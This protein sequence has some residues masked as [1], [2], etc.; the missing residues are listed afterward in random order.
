MTSSCERRVIAAPDALG[1]AMARTPD[2]RD[3]RGEDRV[4][5]GA[6]AVAA[7]AARLTG[8]AQGWSVGWSEGMAAAR[9]NAEREL[10]A[11]QERARAEDARRAAHVEAATAGLRRAASELEAHL[12]RVEARLAD[13]AVELA[14]AVTAAVLGDAAAGQSAAEVVR[15][16]LAQVEAGETAVVRLSPACAAE[17]DTASLP[18]SVSVRPDASLSTGEALVDLVDGVVDLRL[19]AALERVRQV[20]G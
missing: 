14:L 13:Q 12:E 3:G 19:G 4:A 16:A 17:V 20:L 18:A 15:R 1:A 8:R 11:G 7:E 10:S 5:R 6:F 9:E 2:L